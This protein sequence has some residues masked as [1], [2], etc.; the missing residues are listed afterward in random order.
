QICIR[1]EADFVDGCLLYKQFAQ[2]FGVGNG[3]NCVASDNGEP[4]IVLAQ[5]PAQRYKRDEE[6]PLHHKRRPHIRKRMLIL[7]CGAIFDVPWGN[8]VCPN[9]GWIRNDE[10][11]ALREIANPA[12]DALSSGKRL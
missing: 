4:P 2:L 6:I 8:L 3:L 11:E 9:I 12:L 10:V 1:K 5:V 7:Q